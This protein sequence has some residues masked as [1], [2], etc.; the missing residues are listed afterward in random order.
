MKK[1]NKIAGTLMAVT[2][3]VCLCLTSCFKDDSTLGTGEV[4]DIVVSGME[5]AYSGVAFVGEHLKI[6]PK[7]EAGYDAS[8]L[9]Y[10]W[11]LLDTKTGSVTENGDTVRPKVIGDGKDLDFEINVAPGKYQLRLVVTAQSN[12]YKAYASSSLMVRTNFSQGFYILKETADGNTDLDMYTPDDKMGEN[13]LTEM[14]GAPMAGK[15]LALDINYNAWYIN[16]DDDKMASTNTVTVITDRKQ[17]AVKRTADLKTVFDRSNLLYDTMDADEQPYGLVNTVM[18]NICYLS[19]KGVRLTNAAGGSGSSESS[20]QFGMPTS[21]CD[22][23]RFITHDLPSYGGLVF[24]DNATHTIMQT[25]YNGTASPLTYSDNSGTDQ[26]SELASFDCLHIGYNYMSGTGTAT[27]ILE[28]KSTGRRYLYTTTSSF[29]GIFLKKRTVIPA[30]LHLAKDNVFCTNGKT[31]KYIYS[32]DGTALYAGIFGNDELGEA[33]LHPKG[34][35]SGET[36]SYIG[37][38]FWAGSFSGGT[39]FNY[40]VVGTQKGDSYTL[41]MYNMVGGAPEGDPVKIIK[42]TGQVKAV[43]Y[44]NSSFNS[45]DWMFGYHVFNIND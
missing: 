19:S 41:Y 7:V 30:N 26:T 32:S 45:S 4:G 39:K 5:D 9:D 37:N 12:G 11:L 44:L 13:L 34:I 8:D 25:S 6:S 21:E 33:V 15:P 1:N 14:D 40:L 17:I 43:R 42:G 16:P 23:S 35:G 3:L 2:V 36:I 20:G 18:G 24:W 38:P 27:V 28:D 31:A 10:Q 22:G 29:S